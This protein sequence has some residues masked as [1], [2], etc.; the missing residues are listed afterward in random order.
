MLG[1]RS[2][3]WKGAFMVLQGGFEDV[4][5]IFEC[6]GTP[7]IMWV[8]MSATLTEKLNHTYELLLSLSSEDMSAE[9]AQMLGQVGTMTFSRSRQMRVVTG[10]VSQVNE[11]R[12]GMERI[13]TNITIEPALE[14]LRHRV[15]TRIFQDKSVPEILEDVLTEGLQPYTRSVELR[16]DRTYPTC[17]YRVQ[18]DESDLTFCQRLMEEEGIVSFFETEGEAELLVLIDKDSR[19]GTIEPVEGSAFQFSEY[20][21]G[22]N[23]EHVS[24][25]SVISQVQ[26]TKYVSRHYDWAHPTV[27][28]EGESEPGSSD[29]V[30]NGAVIDPEREIY[31]HDTAPLTAEPGGTIYGSDK[32]DQVR[33]RRE[34]QAIDARMALGRSS[35]LEMRPGVVFELAGHPRAD[36]DGRYLALELIHN[37]DS[38]GKQYHNQFRCIP[39]SVSYRPMR[40][41][42]KPR[43][44]SIQ[45]A[46]VVGPS[47]EEIHTD[48][49]GRV[50]VRFHWDRLG[51]WSCWL[52]VMQ[53]W[54][55]TGWGFFF[56]PRI[57]MEVMVSFVNGDPDSPV[58]IGSLYNGENLTP[59]QLP[60]EKTKSTIMTRSSLESEGF[61]E[62]R[63]E[64]KADEEEIY[65]H[66][67]KD[68]NEHVL[69]DHSTQVD[70]DQKNTVDA[71]QTELVKKN[72]K[73]TV[74]KNRK[75]TVKKNEKNTI[76]GNRTTTVKKNEKIV[77][78][79]KRLKTVKKDEK[80]AI[81]GNRTE[82]VKKNE[83][84][85]IKGKADY[86]VKKNHTTKIGKGKVVKVGSGYA[87]MVDKGI[88]AKAKKKIV[89][90]AGKSSITLKEDGTIELKCEKL[91]LKAGSEIKAAGG[92][93]ELTMD[94]SSASLSSSE[95]SITGDSSVTV[96]G[97][98]VD[99]N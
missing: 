25:F 86:I 32:D 77:V 8:V 66:A 14:A 98:S 48:E 81:G 60:D 11:G 61:N 91:E 27:K 22:V 90:K 57:G 19:Y 83:K 67:Q 76:G 42:P 92:S 74:K 53:P 97:G 99:L 2:S 65:V 49:H 54:A 56:I 3:I 34:E 95:V 84:I 7:E 10:V 44:Q 47:G 63:F 72:Q 45:T 36:L 37:F 20:S 82:I 12:A 35:A 9:P 23:Y 26:P 75:K 89:L 64:D 38:G 6:E 46:T 43:I 40:V 28:L 16:L 5:L 70:H 24:S 73:L 39:A 18:L 58:I 79:G 62:L 68:Y 30:P 78:K 33:L 69:N 21:G 41:T 52:R 59:Y 13:N 94:D 51:R 71:D 31:E 15:N 17:D 50:R 96:E 29:D 87:L 55:G 1:E 4:R 88:L 93:T 80:T 85:G